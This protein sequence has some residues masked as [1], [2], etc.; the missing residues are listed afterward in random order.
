MK[1]TLSEIQTHQK[2]IAI[3]GDKWKDKQVQRGNENSRYL[4]GFH[5]R[6]IGII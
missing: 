4:N 6:Y 1:F 3:W 5:D 2:D